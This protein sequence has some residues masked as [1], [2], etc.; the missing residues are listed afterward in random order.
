VRRLAV[1]GCAA[2][3]A[4]FAAAG[5]ATAATDTGNRALVSRVLVISLPNVE[6][7][8]VQGSGVQGSDVQ[9]SGVQG[10]GVQ[11]SGLANLDRL[12][13][14][15]SVGGLVTNGVTRPSPIANSYVTLGAGTR[16][17]A[18]SQTAG[19]GFGVGEDFGRDR[20]GRVFATRT[21]NR[22]GN[23]IVYLPIADVVD[24]NA[25]ELYGAEPG[26]LGDE[27]AA[28]GIGRAV[29]ANGDGSDPS[30]PE[31]R[32]PPFRRSAVAALMTGD[33]KLPAGRVDRELVQNDP[34]APFGLRLDPAAVLTAFRDAWTDRS[35]VLVEGSDLVRA[36]LAGR[37]ASDEQRDRLRA[38]ALRDTDR[39]VGRLLAEVD[40]ARD[41]VIVVGP[42]PPNERP[43]LTTVA[44]RA[45]GFAP[46]LLRSTTTRHDGFVNMVDVAPTILHLFGLERPEAMEGRQMKTGDAG[47]TL[48]SRVG[49]LVDTNEDGLFRDS[50][51]GAS[52]TTVIVIACVLAVG[53]ALVDQI[54]RRTERWGRRG[55][56]A[57]AFLALVLIGF[58]DAT[59]VA[60][61]LHFGRHG[62]AAAY[63][64]FV[65]VVAIVL[66]GAFVALAR[67]ALARALLIGLASVVVLHVVDL[68]TG[69]HLEW[70]TVFGYSPTIG[71]RFVGE[72]NLTFAQLSAAAVLFAGLLAWQV[73]TRT[74]ARVAI[75]VLA[76]TIVVMGVPTWGN[77]FGAVLSALPG[78]ALLGWLLLGHRIR[79]RT[80]AAIAGVVVGA[81]VAVG[82][83]DLLRAPDQRTHVGKFFQKVGTDLD[84]AT[85][86]IRRKA[87]ANLSVFGHSVLLGTVVVVALLVAFLWYVEPRSLRPLARAIPTAATTVLAF[88]VV[89][90]LGSALNDSGISIAGMMFAVFESALVVLVAWSSL[91]PPSR[92]PPVQAAEP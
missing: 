44:V 20:A 11:G 53:T 15:S 92:P 29:V 76:V 22:P 46:G 42:V 38:R 71:I 84:G 25:S 21:G 52:M 7:S 56:W 64:V 91:T 85:L 6:W 27:L 78:F 67:R 66:A 9:G 23:G 72:G 28:A 50:Q 12:F 80:V 82:L 43:A 19:Q 69:A 39:L 37:F 51:V 1:G 13:A 16:A 40:P 62:G 90:V 18:G 83:V 74:G 24:E 65:A 59:Y 63:W 17:S 35:V 79:A 26:L 2:L 81:V 31:D 55:A 60:G 75:G 77:D 5:P 61:P 8:D 33:G 45:P 32:V 68:V 14:A 48:A 36:D 34:S 4:I 47:G 89:A 10:S 3:A 54:R 30:T 57:V 49:F 70:N 41:A 87:S 58:L 73:P 86:V 88:L